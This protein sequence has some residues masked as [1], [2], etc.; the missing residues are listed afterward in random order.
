MIEQYYLFGKDENGILRGLPTHMKMHALIIGATNTGKSTLLR[1]LALS[2]LMN[3]EGFMVIDPHGQ[4][5]ESI[6]KYI[7]RSR[8]DDL[9]YIS[10]K[11]IKKYGYVVKINPLKL[12]NTPQDTEILIDSIKKIYVEGGY[13]RWGDRLE[14]ILRT[15]IMLVS[16]MENARFSDIYRILIDKYYREELVGR[17]KDKELKWFW[18]EEYEDLDSSAYT[19]VMNK[20]QPFLFNDALKPIFDT[21]RTTINIVELM[22]SGKIVIVDIPVSLLSDTGTSF[23]GT[24]II[25]M[26]YLSSFKR[27]SKRPFHIIVDEAYKFLHGYLKNIFMELRKYNVFLTLA[28]HS[29]LQFDKDI[30][31]II[32]EQSHTYVIFRTDQQSAKL[33]AG[34]L[35]GLLRPEMITTLPDHCF[36]CVNRRWSPSDNEVGLIK[37]SAWTIPDHEIKATSEVIDPDSALMMSVKKYGEPVGE[38]SDYTEGIH[39]TLIEGVDR[40]SLTPKEYMILCYMRF[41]GLTDEESIYEYMRDVAGWNPG[42]VKSALDKLFTKHYIYRKRVHGKVQYLVTKEADDEFFRIEFKGGRSGGERH[43][44]IIRKLA[45]DYMYLGYYTVVDRGDEV[46]VDKPDIVIYPYI[47]DNGIV[48]PDAWDVNR[49]MAIEVIL[50]GKVEKA[51]MNWAKAVKLGIRNVIIYTDS[52]DKAIMFNEAFRDR[53]KVSKVVKRVFGDVRPSVMERLN[54]VVIKVIEEEELEAVTKVEEIE[55]EEEKEELKGVEVAEGEGLTLFPEEETD[56]DEFI[57]SYAMQLLKR[58]RYRTLVKALRERGLSDAEQ[59]G[60]TY[61]GRLIIF[62]KDGRA[63]IYGVPDDDAK[64][65][66]E[67]YRRKGYR[68]VKKVVRGRPTLYA[69]KRVRKKWKSI[70][71]GIDVPEDSEERIVELKE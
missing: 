67:E 58:R 70:Y 26:V 46:G 2:S 36:I 65:K 53:D 57:R 40:P 49:A 38:M 68:I 5:A 7:P 23:L 56:L 16:H 18:M 44:D 21:D 6:L 61:D 1:T 52:K 42:I 4:L 8:A 12:T 55:K 17:I 64:K 9:V 13:G 27:R 25:N 29:L 59:V 28:V 15:S 19:A 47:S 22:D 30:R 41:R 69:Q 63:I 34:D 32:Q 48:N 33:I 31:S 60:M 20:L 43:R 54:G 50:H 71:L 37:F 24:L 10:P 3:G 11:S 51:I 35:G 62:T 39:P 14:R 66:V 45:R